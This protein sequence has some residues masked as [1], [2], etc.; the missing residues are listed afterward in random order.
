MN[1]FLH[2]KVNFK[3]S[4]LQ[5]HTKRRSFREEEKEPKIEGDPEVGDDYQ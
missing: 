2:R 5:L 1:K 4:V 3:F